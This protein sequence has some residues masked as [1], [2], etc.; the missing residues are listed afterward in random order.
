MSITKKDKNGI[1]IKYDNCG[2]SVIPLNCPYIG[3]RLDCK[4]CT[5][6]KPNYKVLETRIAELQAREFT[7]E[8]IH[9][10]K[11]NL[12]LNNPNKDGAYDMWTTIRVKCD[13]IMSEKG[14][15]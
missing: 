1:E 5:D 8:E 12:D 13:A 2:A 9:F 6:F 15:E 4:N 10:I 11:C 7:R 14:A 3:G